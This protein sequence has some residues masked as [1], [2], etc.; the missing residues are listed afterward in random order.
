MK[1]EGKD[2]SLLESIE[3]T[4]KDGE[5]WYIPTIPDQNNQ[6]QIPFKLVGAKGYYFVFENPEHDFPQRIIY[7]LKSA[8]AATKYVPT[9]GDLLFVR[10][11]NLEGIKGID[12]N[13]VRE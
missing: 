12:Y 5:F 13:F 6:R 3:L 9:Q 11:E 4:Y 10:V 1:I 8:N 7:H 2:T